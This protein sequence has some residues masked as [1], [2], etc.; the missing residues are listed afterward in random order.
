[1]YRHVAFRGHSS[2]EKESWRWGGESQK[3][4]IPTREGVASDL[5]SCGDL[6]GVRQRRG[7]KM[8]RPQS[9]DAAINLSARTCHCKGISNFTCKMYTV[10][11]ARTLRKWSWAGLADLCNTNINL[12]HYCLS[13]CSLNPPFKL[14]NPFSSGGKR[15]SQNFTLM[16]R[17]HCVFH[18]AQE[19]G[20]LPV[21]WKFKSKQFYAIY[22]KIIADRTSSDRRGVGTRHQRRPLDSNWRRR[23]TKL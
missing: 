16:W 2:T 19:K 22:H 11:R 8:V 4:E 5:P 3:S 1:M 7:R 6:S 14:L 20:K 21:C 12:C 23:F 17:V 13:F 15:V 10:N 18:C 9:V